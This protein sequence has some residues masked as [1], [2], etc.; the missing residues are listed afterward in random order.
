MNLL[1]DWLISTLLVQDVYILTSYLFTKSYMAQL[2]TVF[3]SATLIYQSPL[4]ILETDSP[5][6]FLLTKHYPA[7]FP[8]FTEH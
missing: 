3:C 1:E 8:L 2:M 5:S 6:T 4:L 7:F